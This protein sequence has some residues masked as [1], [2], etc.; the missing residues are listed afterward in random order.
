[1]NEE[2]GRTAPFGTAEVTGW[3][4][5]QLLQLHLRLPACS[6]ACTMFPS[7]QASPAACSTTGC[8]NRASLPCSQRA[9]LG[10]TPVTAV[11]TGVGVGGGATPLPGWISQFFSLSLTFCSCKMGHY[12]WRAAL[13]P[14]VMK[15]SENFADPG[16]ASCGTSHA[17]YLCLELGFGIF[18]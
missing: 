15:C 17:W 1:M 13:A 9:V 3:D 2:R 8:R 18:T 12:F 5:R 10:L 14:A 7:S 6:T 16:K 4:P 11:C